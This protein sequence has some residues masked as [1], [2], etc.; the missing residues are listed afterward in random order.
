M[1]QRVLIASLLFLSIL[2]FADS[3]YLAEKAATNTPLFCNVGAWFD[4]CNTVAQSPYSKFFGVPLAYF[5]V[6]FYALMILVAALIAWKPQRLWYLAL[7]IVAI[8]GAVLSAVFLFIQ[9]ALIQ[10]LCIYCIISA[11]ISFCNLLLAWKVYPR[12]LRID[13]VIA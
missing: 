13:A 11:I 2:G 3:F 8:V 10:A 7:L 1:I 9:F 4:G 5:G 12:S 6:A